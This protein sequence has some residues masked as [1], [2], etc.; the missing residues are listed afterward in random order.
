MSKLYR[1]CRLCYYEVGSNQFFESLEMRFRN[2]W[3]RIE[4][5]Q[6][7]IRTFLNSSQ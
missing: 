6:K 3:G 5:E 2:F 7:N 1:D 4:P